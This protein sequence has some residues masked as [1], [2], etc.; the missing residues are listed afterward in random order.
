VSDNLRNIVFGKWAELGVQPWFASFVEQNVRLTQLAALGA[1]AFELGFVVALFFRRARAVAVVTG[2]AFHLA[3]RYVLYIDFWPLYW[4]Y[5]VFVP[6]DRV[7]GWVGRTLFP[8][9]LVA[10]YDGG[11]GICRRTVATLRA[12]DLLGRVDW[13][14]AQDAVTDLPRDAL[15]RDLHAVE[16]DRVTV[17]FAAY[18]RIALRY[19]LLWPALPFAYLP[20]VAALGRRVYRRVADTRACAVA[21]LPA[22]AGPTVTPARPRAVAAVFGAVALPAVLLGFAGIEQAW[23]VSAYPGFR[24][25]RGPTIERLAAHDA[26]GRPLDLRATLGYTTH[27]WTTLSRRVSRMDAPDRTAEARRLVDAAAARDPALRAT[28]VTVVLDHVP[29]APSRRGA[30]PERREVL[31]VVPGA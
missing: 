6:W 12:V 14:P 19:P 26:A 20:P 13:V 17:G 3:N 16:G 10:L 9:P 25:L 27:A 31:A 5:V 4:L 28:A 29:T 15:L 8:R 30:P 11:C 1:M 2:F 24:G 22:P 21:P 18:R 23:P 7:L